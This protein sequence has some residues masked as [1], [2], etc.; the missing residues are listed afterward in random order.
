MNETVDAAQLL[1][2]GV[3]AGVGMLVAGATDGAAEPRAG[4]GVQVAAACKALGA[5]VE[6]CPADSVASAPS[7]PGGFDVL[8]VDAA[9]LFAAGGTGPAEADEA[10]ATAERTAL[11]A[12]LDGAWQA[13]HA[14][15][16]AL[17]AAQRPGRVVYLA[18][19]CE[20]AG[21]TPHGLADAARAGL[22]NLARTLS[23]EWARYAITT[24]AIAPG[25]STTAA[26]LA[27][28][29]AYLAS[30][31]GDYFSGCMLDLRGPAASTAR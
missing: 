5:R 28:L 3:L 19:A 11:S 17:I 27:S 25:A 18:P 30:P 1:R 13:T 26:Q 6:L 23:I 12:C 15:A 16:E 10:L 8:V 2:A 9:A 22:E 31:A 21:A 14:V 29:C 4:Y 7:L 20:P 24:V